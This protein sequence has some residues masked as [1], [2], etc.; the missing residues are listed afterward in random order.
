LEISIQSAK[1]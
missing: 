1:S